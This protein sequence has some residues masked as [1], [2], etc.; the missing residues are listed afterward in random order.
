[1]QCWKCPPVGAKKV[2]WLS[3]PKTQAKL[4]IRHWHT[5][6]ILQHDKWPQQA[7]LVRLQNI[8]KILRCFH[9][10]RWLIITDLRGCVRVGNISVPISQWKQAVTENC[11]NWNRLNTFISK[12]RTSVKFRSLFSFPWFPSSSSS[13]NQ[14][15][16]EIFNMKGS[17][18][19][20]FYTVAK[21]SNLPMKLRLAMTRTTLCR[22]D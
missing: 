21:W 17:E 20:D 1:M 6:H 7:S 3:N 5:M 10:R 22:S 18:A 2:G 4:D 11:S 8:Y 16:P 12:I 13:S 14:Q 15:L 19:N 9:W